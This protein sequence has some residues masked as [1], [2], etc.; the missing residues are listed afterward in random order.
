MENMLTNPQSE[1]HTREN[2][3]FLDRV[4]GRNNMGSVEMN[5]PRARSVGSSRRRDI[6]RLLCL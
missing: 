3:G 1:I 5:L 2:I 6:C 4:Q